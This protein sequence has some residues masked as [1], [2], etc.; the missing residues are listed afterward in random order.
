[1]PI[2][3]G[4][5]PFPRSFGGA[6]GGVTTIQ[7]VLDSLNS[8]KGTAYDTNAGTNVWVENMAYARAIANAWGTNQRV[9]NQFDPTRTTT[10]L[11]RWEAIFGRTPMPSD[12][13]NGRRAGIADIWSRFGVI[14]TPQAIQTN[15]AAVLGPAVFVSVTHETIASALTYWPGGTPSTL[16]PWYST[17][18]RLAVQI[19]QPAGMLDGEFYALIQNMNQMLDQ[20]LPIWCTWLWWRADAVNGL[21]GFFL[22]SANN[23]DNSAFDV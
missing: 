15:L 23:I 7:V 21:K 18:D 2:C 19:T 8:A 22:D 11:R 13:P 4:F 20:R 3:G 6:K 9:A 14:P 10:M 12:T 5:A 17:I 1:M 16:A